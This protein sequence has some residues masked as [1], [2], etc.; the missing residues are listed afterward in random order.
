MLAGQ[1]VPSSPFCLS[2]FLGNKTVADLPH[3]DEKNAADLTFVCTK[4]FHSIFHIIFSNLC[5]KQYT[6]SLS[7]SAEI[8]K[9]ADLLLIGS[10]DKSCSRP[11]LLHLS[12]TIVSRI[13]RSKETG[14]S[15]LNGWRKGRN[16]SSLAGSLSLLLPFASS[17][18]AVICTWT[19]IYSKSSSY[20]WLKFTI[21]DGQNLL[22]GAGRNVDVQEG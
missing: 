22:L 14:C 2:S 7:L 5:W 6:Q 11:T 19:K 12:R 17:A 8:E 16:G 15:C 18:V 10:R 4:N 21:G 20:C 1:L 13:Q 9:V 3:F